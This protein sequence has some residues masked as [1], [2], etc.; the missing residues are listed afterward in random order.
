MP[1]FPQHLGDRLLALKLCRPA[2]LEA[3]QASIRRMYQGLPE[4]ESVWLDALVQLR[5]ITPWQSEQLQSGADHT[6]RLADMTL[7]EPLGN[8]SFLAQLEPGPGQ[9]TASAVFVR[10]LTSDA[11]VMAGPSG[12]GSASAATSLSAFGTSSHQ[13]SL[14]DRVRR[15]LEELPPA[16]QHAAIALPDRLL[17]EDTPGSEDA[18]ANHSAKDTLAANTKAEPR[19]FLQSEFVAGWSAD[20]LLVRGGRLPWPAVAEIGRQLLS[21]LTELEQA[22]Y[23]HGEITRRH[24]RLRPDGRAVLVAPFV[25]QLQQPAVSIA[26]VGSLEDVEGVAPERVG[27]GRPVDARSELY[28]LGCLLWQL[29]TARPPFLSADPV[30]MLHQAQT[31]EL[32]SLRELVPDCPEWLAT[33]IHAMSRRGAELRP[34]SFAAAAEHW[35]RTSGGLR[36]LKNLLRTMPDR[37]Q[38]RAADPPRGRLPQALI[39]SC[40]L[41]PLFGFYAWHRGLLPQT[42][43]LGPDAV[44]PAQTDAVAASPPGSP[45]TS[46]MATGNAGSADGPG[47]LRDDLRQASGDS[48][49]VLPLPPPDLAGVVQLQSGQ[50][51]AAS[52]LQFAGVMHIESHAREPA[53]VLVTDGWKIQASHVVLTGLRI[54]AATATAPSAVR[55]LVIDSHLLS[56]QSCVIGTAAAGFAG[57]SV[58][59]TP[60]PGETRVLKIRDVEFCGPDYGLWIRDTPGRMEL[61]NV[62]FRQQG[63]AVRLDA[64]DLQDVRCDMTRVTQIGG[65]SF[66]DVVPTGD[67]SRDVRITIRSGESVLAPAAAVVRLAPSATQSAENVRIEF[68]LPEQGNPTIVPPEVNPAVYYD[69]SL[70]QMT[71]FDSS[72]VHSESLLFARPVFR[73]KPEADAPADTSGA[74]DADPRAAWELIDYEGPK[75]NAEL[76]GFRLAELP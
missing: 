30:T 27:S 54:E 21:G 1:S 10:Q 67:S 41:L 7:C 73:G 48:G 32:P 33:Q 50:T 53:R 61:R 69:R 29:L 43:Q 8:V 58:T 37:R 22:G 63:G 57:G 64:D 62:L 45:A 65:H 28:A 13:P 20:A 34:A 3:C 24:L 14:R 36:C 40:L 12:R 5:V 16:L 70:G 15:L 17:E 19:A 71:E 52:D 68:L 25:K 4:F 9:R 38:V 56:L 49:P 26:A 31:R 74:A 66:W 59:W 55:G 75:L 6:I 42:L 18:T 44:D 46:A 11:G 51:Y 35:P 76:P 39:A 23:L 47:L 72:H 2:D 60:Q